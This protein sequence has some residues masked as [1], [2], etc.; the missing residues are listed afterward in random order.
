M[1]YVIA[2]IGSNH[3]G[4]FE[5]ACDLISLAARSDADAVK[6]QCLPNLPQKWLPKLQMV[7]VEFGVDLLAT[8]FDVDAVRV[9]AILGVPYIK[10]ASPEIVNLDLI[11]TAAST[12]IPLLISTGMASILEIQRA[13]DAVGAT[14]D[15]TLLQ[16]T[17]R[18]PTPL[19]QIHLR[20]MTGMR[21]M[22]GVPV[23]LSD[24]SMST[25]IPA[26]AAALGA[27]M[28][29]KHITLDPRLEGPDHHFALGPTTF[30]AMVAGIR[31]V[32]RAMG[33]GI[34]SGPRDGEAIEARG[35]RLQ[36]QT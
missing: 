36:W 30:P 20:A 21:D 7:A 27:T 9:L 14:N 4:K 6:F 28:I 17:T 12:D 19:E 35:R 31:E 22:F 11:E 3:D 33:D 23:G 26:A 1:T 25:V 18:Y 5:Q 15:V 16:C 2:E 8:P 10:I 32:E 24:H 13:L 34:K 29:E